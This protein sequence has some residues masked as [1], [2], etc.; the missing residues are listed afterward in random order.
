[1]RVDGAG[2]G[3]K[4]KTH[5][6]SVLE[7]RLVGTLG[8][9]EGGTHLNRHLVVEEGGVLEE[10]RSVGGLGETE[11]S[12]LPT[13]SESRRGIG[14]DSGSEDLKSLGTSTDL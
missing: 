1:M 13:R 10:S 3:K 4:D 12:A 7:S 14:L 9:T 5:L 6:R 11:R 8:G 2:K